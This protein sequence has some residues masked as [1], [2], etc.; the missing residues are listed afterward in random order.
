MGR[1]ELGG[2]PG[3]LLELLFKGHRVGR[4]PQLKELWIA[5]F[6]STL[7]FIWQTRNRCKFEGIVPN[8]MHA[9][10][11]ISG[12]VNTSGRIATG[13]MF[14]SIQDL[15]V[16]KRFGV[17]CKPRR[18]PRIIEV[19]RHPPLIGWVKINTDGAWK[20]NSPS[21]GYGGVFRDYKGEVLG[22]FS[23]SLDIPSSVAAKVMVVIKAIEL[24][25]VRDWKH[26][27]LEVDSS[28]VLTFLRSPHMVP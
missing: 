22:A 23:S 17:P 11:M 24:A 26:V 15:C 28:L 21:A 12:Y 8:A 13:C 2:L 5:C 19:N 10:R 14:N 16:V 9:C 1:F 25:W 3:T 20:M 6:C 7:W 27:W 18:A 4:S